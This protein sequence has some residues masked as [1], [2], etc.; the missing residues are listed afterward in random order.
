MER[1]RDGEFGYNGNGEKNEE[2]PFYLASTNS[3]DGYH[4][5]ANVKRLSRCDEKARVGYNTIC[6]PFFK[7]NNQSDFHRYSN[8]APSLTA[9]ASTSGMSYSL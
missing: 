1:I 2:T 9:G 7:I 4:R 5:N 3:R 8:N 6:A